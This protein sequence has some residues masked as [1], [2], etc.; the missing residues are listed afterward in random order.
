M[1][2]A[3]ILVDPRPRKDGAADQDLEMGDQTVLSAVCL[4]H[5]G[6]CAR[7]SGLIFAATDV[8]PWLRLLTRSLNP[9]RHASEQVIKNT[10]QPLDDPHGGLG[11][12]HDE[13]VL[14]YAPAALKQ[15]QA[16][17][18]GHLGQRCRALLARCRRCLPGRDEA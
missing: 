7:V 17:G 9:H 4:A 13:N 12:P 16:P 11:L 14:V 1:R 15:H 10:E 8:A 6:V 3:A 2:V 18:D 5:D